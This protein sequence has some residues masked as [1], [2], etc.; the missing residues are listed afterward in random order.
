MF[1]CLKYLG[2][3]FFLSV[4]IFKCPKLLRKVPCKAV[5]DTSLTS[6]TIRFA[7]TVFH[8]FKIVDSPILTVNNTPSTFN[9]SYYFR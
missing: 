1:S 7:L 6:K 4:Y 8:L 9:L 5:R 3:L 2:C